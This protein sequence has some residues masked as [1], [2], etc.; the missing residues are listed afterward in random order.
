MKTIKTNLDDARETRKI[1]LFLADNHLMVREGLKAMLSAQPDMG[2][3]GEAGNG[4]ETCRK[5]PILKPDV[6]V[7]KLC[8]P[9][10]SGLQVVEHLKTACPEAKVLF[11]TFQEEEIYV[12]A[13]LSAQVRGYVLKRS[14]VEE[15]FLAIR[16]IADGGV[17]FDSS[18]AGKFLAD[19][20]GR[21]AASRGPLTTT[22]TRQEKRVL[23][24]AAQGFTN[25]EIANTLS[26]SVKTIE[27]Y[28]LR[29]AEKLNLHSRVDIVRYALQRGWLAEAFGPH[30]VPLKN[31]VPQGSPSPRS[32]LGHNPG[33]SVSRRSYRQE[34]V[35]ARLRT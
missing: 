4:R 34:T 7:L 19:G 1:R 11:L 15:L 18:L 27:S 9:E 3:V 29:L 16:K 31:V 22:P 20:F 13:A 35:G 23:V 2:V 8:L 12:R 14:P 32:A 33:A 26:V 17:H 5:I 30:F 24:L 28:K 10:L 25:K 6:A 21:P